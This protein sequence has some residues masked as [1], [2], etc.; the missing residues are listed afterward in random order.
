LY[1]FERCTI[2]TSNPIVAEPEPCRSRIIFLAGARARARA[3]SKCKKFLISHINFRTISN[4]VLGTWK[5][6]GQTNPGHDKPRV[7]VL[8]V[9]RNRKIKKLEFVA[10]HS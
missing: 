9:R 4:D 2:S 3:E 10:D 1:Y 7:I 8:G 6:P 5:N